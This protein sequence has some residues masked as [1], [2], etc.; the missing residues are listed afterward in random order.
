MATLSAAFFWLGRLLHWV[1]RALLNLLTLTLLVAIGFG[2]F[3]ALHRPGVPSDALLVVAPRGHLVY[4]RSESPW[5]RA[6]DRLFGHS[7][8]EVLIR[9]LTTAIDRATDDPRI[10]VM[11]V[12]LQDFQGGSI[13]QLQTVARALRRFRK[14]G[15]SIYA[16]ASTYSQGDYL[17]AAQADHIYLSPLGA[18]LITGYAHYQPYFKQLLHRLGVKVYVFRKGKYKSAAEPF[19]RTDMSS[20]AKEEADAWL[21]TWWSSYKES[22]AT[23]RGL[24]AEQIQTY[25]QNLPQL[26]TAANGDTARLALQRGLVSA[27]GDA[28]AFTMAIAKALGR[29]D[30]AAPQIGY[31]RYLAA[32]GSGH[33]GGPAVAV[34][35]LD[36]MLVSGKGWAPGVVA[37]RPTVD[38]LDRLVDDKLVRAVVL[39]VNSPGGS[40]DAAEA[41]RQAVLRL[42]KA[43]KPVVVSM[44]TLGASGA[45]WLSTAAQAIYARPTT[46]TADIGVFALFPNFADTLGKV[47][48]NISGVANTPTAGALSPLMPL[49]PDIAKT[50]QG[51][52][53]YLYTRFVDL[54]AKSRGLTLD[55]ADQIAQGRAWSGEDALRLKLV[56]KLGGVHQAIDAAAR[57]AELQA[58]RYHV[59]YL[60]RAEQPGVLSA[61][62]PSVTLGPVG[63]DTGP[64]ATVRAAAQ[65][66]GV[67]DREARNLAL[68][69]RRAHPYG[70]FAYC[71]TAPPQ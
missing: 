52:V 33:R 45:Y 4:S 3:Q 11:A 50:M 32:T 41:I 5:Q 38:Q 36:G 35:P 1:R 20:A 60:S 8:R 49:K 15:K 68:L 28:H 14:A 53:D 48:I 61:I 51:S 24:K 17:L 66:L 58:G 9:H 46:I 7:P 43:G 12:D 69:L 59:R 25:A 22:V 57:L 42:R 30:G 34:V 37:A 65:A 2:V 19:V 23:A 70:V 44:G 64:L 63:T 54:V 13:T 47:G 21:K 16:Y 62:E 26:I 18:V 27:L 31:R 29:A 71:P 6:V 55:Q 67:H 40:V 56:D 10:K 39:Q